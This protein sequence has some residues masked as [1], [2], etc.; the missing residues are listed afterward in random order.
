MRGDATNLG[1]V[2]DEPIGDD[3]VF[4]AHGFQV[5]RKDVKCERSDL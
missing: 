3:L 5:I 1:L 2:M 4:D